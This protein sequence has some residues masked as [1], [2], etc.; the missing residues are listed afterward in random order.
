MLSAAR[1]ANGLGLRQNV[2]GF[3][4]G[5]LTADVVIFYR[6]RNGKGVRLE[7]VIAH[8]LAKIKDQGGISIL[9]LFVLPGQNLGQV[10]HALVAR[11]RV[12]GFLLP[13]L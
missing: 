12:H 1:R 6:N 10:V 5:Q 7:A 4:K 9:I 3:A 13:L 2:P 8:D 11:T